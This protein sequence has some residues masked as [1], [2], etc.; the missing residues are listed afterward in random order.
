MAVHVMSWDVIKWIINT[1]LKRA[2]TAHFHAD[3]KRIQRSIWKQIKLPFYGTNIAFGVFAVAFGWHDVHLRVV[4]LHRIKKGLARRIAV[5]WL[6]SDIIG[7]TVGLGLYIADW[8]ATVIR[9]VL[10][11][12]TFSAATKIAAAAL[13]ASLSSLAGIFCL[14]LYPIFVFVG[15]VLSSLSYFAQAQKYL[16]EWNRQLPLMSTQFNRFFCPHL[17]LADSH[18]GGSTN[19]PLTHFR[20]AT[21]GVI[22]RDTLS[23]LNVVAFQVFDTHYTAS[24]DKTF[25]DT[26]PYTTKLAFPQRTTVVQVSLE[27]LELPLNI[28]D[29]AGTVTCEH[30]SWK[31]V[32]AEKISW[33]VFKGLFV[34]VLIYELTQPV[35]TSLLSFEFGKSCASVSGDYTINPGFVDVANVEQVCEQVD[36]ASRRSQEI[37]NLRKKN[38]DME[39][40]QQLYFEYKTPQLKDGYRVVSLDIWKPRLYLYTPA[41]P[42]LGDTTKFITIIYEISFR[43]SPSNANDDEEET[44]GRMGH[45]NIAAPLIDY[46]KARDEKNPQSFTYNVYKTDVRQFLL[47][48]FKCEEKRDEDKDNLTLAQAVDKYWLNIRWDFLR[49]ASYPEG[50]AITM[51]WGDSD[52]KR[53]LRFT[54]LS[55]DARYK[56]VLDRGAYHVSIDY[57]KKTY[58]I[59]L[60]QW[61][62]PEFRTAQIHVLDLALRMMAKYSTWTDEM[63]AHGFTRD[64]TPVQ[65]RLSNHDLLSIAYYNPS[66]APKRPWT[67]FVPKRRYA[68]QTTKRQN[69]AIYGELVGKNTFLPDWD[70]FSMLPLL[71]DARGLLVD[72]NLTSLVDNVTLVTMNVTISMT[73]SPQIEAFSCDLSALKG[74]NV[75]TP[76]RFKL[77]HD[78]LEREYARQGSTGAEYR[79]NLIFNSIEETQTGH[80]VVRKWYSAGTAFTRYVLLEDYEI[81]LGYDTVRQCYLYYALDPDTDNKLN[82]TVKAKWGIVDYDHINDGADTTM[83]ST[84]SWIIEPRNQ[85]DPFVHA[86]AR[87]GK[88]W[89]VTRHNLLYRLGC[90]RAFLREA[91]T[92]APEFLDFVE[93]YEFA[94][95]RTVPAKYMSAPKETVNSV[96]IY[97]IKLFD[98]Y[99]VRSED[100]IHF[101]GFHEV[102]NT[103]L[104]VTEDNVVRLVSAVTYSNATFELVGPSSADDAD[105]YEFVP[106]LTCS[107][108]MDSDVSDESG[109]TTPLMPFVRHTISHKASKRTIR[110]SVDAAKRVTIH[111][112]SEVHDAQTRDHTISPFLSRHASAYVL[113]RLCTDAPQDSCVYRVADIVVLRET[114][115]SV[116]HSTKR[117]DVVLV[118]KSATALVHATIAINGTLS[119]VVVDTT[120]NAGTKHVRLPTVRLADLNNPRVLNVQKEA[121]R[122]IM[123]LELDANVRSLELPDI[124]GHAHLHIA[125]DRSTSDLRVSRTIHLRP[126]THM[127]ASVK[128]VTLYVVN[129]GDIAHRGVVVQSRVCVRMENRDT[130]RRSKPYCGR[131][132]DGDGIEVRVFYISRMPATNS[133]DPLWSTYFLDDDNINSSENGNEDDKEHTFSGTNTTASP[134][135]GICV[136][137]TIVRAYECSCGTQI[138]PSLHVCHAQTCH[139]LDTRAVYDALSTIQTVME[140]LAGAHERSMPRRIT[141]KT[142]AGIVTLNVVFCICSQV[143]A[144]LCEPVRT[145][146]LCDFTL[147]ETGVPRKGMADVG[148]TVLSVAFVLSPDP[149]SFHASVLVEFGHRTNSWCAETLGTA[150][151]TTMNMYCTHILGYENNDVHTCAQ[152]RVFPHMDAYLPHWIAATRYEKFIPE[153]SSCIRVRPPIFHDDEQQ[154]HGANSN[155][156]AYADVPL[157]SSME[158]GFVVIRGTLYQAGRSANDDNTDTLMAQTV[159]KVQY[160][161]VGTLSDSEGEKMHTTSSAYSHLIDSNPLNVTDKWAELKFVKVNMRVAHVFRLLKNLIQLLEDLH[162]SN[163]THNELSA[164]N[165]FIH[166][167]S[168][169]FE[170]VM[171]TEQSEQQ[172]HGVELEEYIEMST[173]ST[174]ALRLVVRNSMRSPW[175]AVGGNH[176]REPFKYSHTVWSSFDR[177][178]INIDKDTADSVRSDIKS[179]CHMAMNLLQVVLPWELARSK[180][181]VWPNPRDIQATDPDMSSLL[182]HDGTFLHS[183]QAMMKMIA[184]LRHTMMAADAD[185]PSRYAQLIRDGPMKDSLERFERYWPELFH[186]TSPLN[187]HYTTRRWLEKKY[188]DHRAHDTP[189]PPFVL[190]IIPAATSIADT[191]RVEDVDDSDVVPSHSHSQRTRHTSTHSDGDSSVGLM[192]STGCHAIT[193]EVDVCTGANTIHRLRIHYDGVHDDPRVLANTTLQH[194]ACHTERAHAKL[195]APMDDVVHGCPY[196]ITHHSFDDVTDIECMQRCRRTP[197]HPSGAHN[198]HA[199]VANTHYAFPG[200]NSTG[201]HCVCYRYD[202]DNDNDGLFGRVPSKK[203]ARFDHGRFCHAIPPRHVCR[204]DADCVMPAQHNGGQARCIA[205]TRGRRDPTKCTR[206]QSRCRC[207][208]L[209]Y[210]TNHGGSRNPCQ[211]ECGNKGYCTVMRM[212]SRVSYTWEYCSRTPI[213]H[214]YCDSFPS[215]GA[216]SSAI[217]FQKMRGAHIMSVTRCTQPIVPHGTECDVISALGYAGGR[218]TCH[219]GEYTIVAATKH[220]VGQQCAV[221]TSC[222]GNSVCYTSDGVRPCEA[223]D[224]NNNAS[225][226]C[227]CMQFRCRTLSN[228]ECLPFTHDGRDR[229]PGCTAYTWKDSGLGGQGY[230]CDTSIMH[231]WDWCAHDKCDMLL[232]CSDEFGAHDEE[233]ESQLLLLGTHIRVVDCRDA[234]VHGSRCRITRWDPGYTGGEVE[235]RNGGHTVVRPAR[236]FNAVKCDKN[237]DCASGSRCLDNKVGE[238]NGDHTLLC[239]V[240]V[241]PTVVGGLNNPCRAF[242]CPARTNNKYRCSGNWFVD[243]DAYADC[244][245]YKAAS[246]HG[247]W[248]AVT[249]TSAYTWDE[250]L[251][252]QCV[253]YVNC[254]GLVP[255]EEL[256]HTNILSV[257]CHHATVHHAACVIEKR[258]ERYIGGSVQCANGKYHIRPAHHSK[259]I[260]DCHEDADCPVGDSFCFDKSNRHS[261]TKCSP[262]SHNCHCASVTCMSDDGYEC[263]TRTGHHIGC[264]SYTKSNT[265]GYYCS[266][267]PRLNPWGYTWDWCMSDKCVQHAN[268][269]GE[270]TPSETVKSGSGIVAAD[271]HNAIFHGDYCTITRRHEGT[272]SGLVQ[273]VDGDYTVV[274]AERFPKKGFCRFNLVTWSPRIGAYSGLGHDACEK[275]CRDTPPCWSV[276]ITD[277]N[278]FEGPMCVLLRADYPHTLAD[279]GDGAEVS[280]EACKTECDAREECKAYAIFTEEDIQKYV[281]NPEQYKGY[282]RPAVCRLYKDDG[283]TDASSS[284]LSHTSTTFEDDSLVYEKT[285]CYAKE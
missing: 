180:Q 3:L 191:L 266:L 181:Q 9:M 25:Y 184:W 59:L 116:P 54:P 75:R 117:S 285:M 209:V 213:T 244:S 253:V 124:A 267:N 223:R 91:P 130:A 270:F 89:G 13:A 136:D 218:V 111:M 56:I 271:C 35:D 5:A 64:R 282:I 189:S 250:C 81:A 123:M 71:A 79:S 233:G 49:L 208:L 114:R 260:R 140:P 38:L 47:L 127:P 112:V 110:Y 202:N 73:G 139:A 193:V 207:S 55:G 146:H 228:A 133:L 157:A 43:A 211:R 182:L 281:L 15:A 100:S 258:T 175:S 107:N 151:S 227:V 279:I 230:Y 93:P 212:Y 80:P 74:N 169:R 220:K 145:Q 85:E 51:R 238:G 48:E 22:G 29:T 68:V 50:T 199:S 40:K 2:V 231:H 269:V 42:P 232:N 128:Y 243:G 12:A 23:H 120:S 108:K 137:N 192:F 242:T 52:D 18:R 11:R 106:P 219:N 237:D 162:A 82:I 256:E 14:I 261:V 186:C 121:E 273:C 53:V 26:L 147:V 21:T 263:N 252:D 221:D 262:R 188:K 156:G 58:A 283:Q 16:H 275:K 265:G 234:H 226:R 45:Y 87:D 214:E 155:Y 179:I 78:A 20:L 61:A 268:C 57:A 69:S 176:K 94:L 96:S 171:A 249:D 170:R 132:A 272:A 166:G 206:A 195:H 225:S 24:L 190:N 134:R 65:I 30:K 101:V 278:S 4:S 10:L 84:D 173:N 39:G 259:I 142:T 115:Q 276:T 167:I 67:M 99:F 138:C 264:S 102:T 280:T 44:D 126:L 197:V 153:S 149:A 144:R 70:I 77:L 88:L 152:Q 251:A 104:F 160:A 240:K 63:E 95:F 187:A 201:R 143:T 185:L 31:S 239:G 235:C 33:E 165:I 168:S 105:D 183:S 158:S 72:Y 119:D 7:W 236:L 34:W 6:A 113:H 19:I 32:Y 154:Q 205:D 194:G 103:G 224:E 161:L 62:S 135:G 37:S 215:V 8:I 1:P 196:A 148:D 28:F 172:E 27:R 129:G 274:P 257:N 204:S 41:V 36:V 66:P 198:R 210:K 141:T 60:W 98:K 284:R 200:G 109:C 174:M 86:F 178:A 83:T 164:K 247:T 222:P 163:I 17:A 90:T 76:C 254:N 246:H 150:Q 46:T 125:V 241:C 122:D 277:A 177:Q 217:A 216:E 97:Y 245:Y 248:C 131:E 92:F 255:E 203:Q 159:E 118:S 229:H